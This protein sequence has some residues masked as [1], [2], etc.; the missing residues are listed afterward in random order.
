MCFVAVLCLYHYKIIM[1]NQSTNENLKGTEEDLNFKPYR[2]GLGRLGLLFRV[3][4]GRLYYTL[5]PNTLVAFS[6]TYKQQ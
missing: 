6:K 1:K 3:F 4:F 2:N 5:V